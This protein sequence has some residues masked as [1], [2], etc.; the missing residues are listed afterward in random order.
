MLFIR[1]FF[2][3]EASRASEVMEPVKKASSSVAEKM[4]D[5]TGNKNIMT[6]FFG[7]LIVA[8]VVFIIA[9]VLYSYLMKKKIQSSKYLLPETKFPILGTEYTKVPGNNIPMSGN[10]KR[11]TIAFWIY[12]NDIDKY[13]GIYRHIWHRGDKD[14]NG[15][16]P[17]IFLDKD[18]TKLHVRFND[19][20][21]PQ[22]ISITQPYNHK[23]EFTSGA[24]TVMKYVDKETDRIVYD[25]ATHGITIDYIPLQRWVHVAVVIN[26]EVNRGSIQA[27]LDGELVKSVESGKTT[28]PIDF[29]EANGANKSSYSQTYEFQ[30]LNLDKPGDVYIGGSLM[31]SA[32]PGFSGLV[33]KITFVNHDLN[34]KDIYNMYIEG[35]IDNLASKLGLPAYGVRSPIYK[36]GS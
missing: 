29:K 26:E 35:P 9:Y 36:I 12:I 17:L 5:I 24:S 33:S 21:N 7:F 18:S 32:G 11:M 3:M 25:L 31:E 2:K 19:I 20:N 28:P 6:V 1:A 13:K 14:I 4:A 27:F 30:N 23:R 15:S 8:I 10:G 34:I 16:S 22:V